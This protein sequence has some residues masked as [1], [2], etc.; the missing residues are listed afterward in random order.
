MRIQFAEPVKLKAAS[1][2]TEFDAYGRR[3]SVDLQRNERLVQ[4]L[5]PAARS[6]T[7]RAQLLRGK[8]QGAQ[9][10][11]VRLTQVGVGLEGAIWDGQEMYVVTTLARIQKNLTTPIAA[12]PGQTVMYRLS[13]TLDSLPEA[14]CGLDELADAAA[15]RG[16]SGLK[17]YRSLVNQLTAAAATTPAEQLSLSLI[18]DSSFQQQ[19]AGS[20]ADAMLARLNI[21]DGIFAEQIGVLLQPTELRLVPAGSDPFSATDASKLLDQ[22]SNFRANTPAVR[23]AGLAH[24]FTGKD[25][26]GNTIG[27]AY[28][29]ALCDPSFGASLS[30]SELGPFSS[31]LVMAHELGHNFGAEHDGTS[32]TCAATGSGYLMSPQF[33]GASV[34]SAC[35]LNSIAQSVAQ[36]RGIC[37]LPAQYADLA[38]SAP[39]TLDA[40]ANT[41]FELPITVRSIGNVAAIGATVKL[42]LPSILTFQGADLPSGACSTAGAEVTCDLG[43]IPANSERVVELNLVSSQLSSTS[44]TATVSAS[45]DYLTANGTTQTYLYFTSA[46]DLGVVMTVS[47]TTLF[48]NDT[49]DV[50]VDVTSTRTLTARGGQLFV[51]LF[52]MKFDSVTAGAHTCTIVFQDHVRCDLADIAAGQTTRIVLHGHGENRGERSVTA[53]VQVADD[54][55][56]RNNSAQETIRI[57]PENDFLIR[58]SAESLSFEP[59]VVQEVTYTLEAIGRIPSVKSQLRVWG[60][61][62]GQFD[63]FV[64]SAGTCTLEGVNSLILCEFG[65]LNPGASLTVTVRFHTT[66]NGSAHLQGEALHYKDAHTVWINGAMTQIYSNL[67]IDAIARTLYASAVEG[68]TSIGY[69]GVES[70]GLQPAQNVVATLEVPAP[71]QLTSMSV[72]NVNT[73]A[74]TLLTPQRGQC[75]GAFTGTGGVSISYGFS[76]DV[77]GDYTAKLTITADGDGDAANN[78][79]ESILTVAPFL[80][81]GIATTETS[82]HLVAGQDHVV[83]LTVTTAARPVPGVIVVAQRNSEFE[84]SSMTAAGSACE[85]DSFSGYGRCQLGDLPANAVVPVSV[86]Y[87]ALHDASTGTARVSVFTSTDHEQTNNSVAIDYTTTIYTD[88]QLQVAQATATAVSGTRLLFPRITISNLGAIGSRTSQLLIPLPAFTTVQSVSASNAACSGTISLSCDLFTLAPGTSGTI[89]IT[90]NTSST[91]NFTSNVTLQGANDSTTG[92]NSAVVELSVT[93]PQTGGG[94]G[95]SSGGGGG[96]TGGSGSSKGGGGQLEWLALVFLA[97][98][99]ADRARRRRL[100]R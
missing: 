6:Q 47:P 14:F 69:A 4:G 94:G 78:T 27:I 36:A 18:A 74:C 35:S 10:S 13:D 12:A 3:F 76:S 37:I 90:L 84:I 2:H 98:L 72:T 95:S 17:Q 82:M 1:G 34:F 51:S 80:D 19:N 23:T 57:S 49:F 25:L 56:Y 70:V 73:W 24:L 5:S 31:A 26:D 64:A 41:P 58:A 63:S 85:I 83:Q 60:P 28:R 97:L 99:V 44:I 87:R 45:N 21:V 22:L 7:A 88:L 65:D 53:Q 75:T 67:Q 9:G 81:A 8:L 68:R 50:T 71:M 29:D 89:D 52:D 92:N 46:V 43:D 38:A 11:W 33:N 61:W 79:S 62:N 15:S 40:Q 86:A 59:G 42:T 16:V 66:S 48:A 100:P 39:A 77:P 30:D 20:S 91:G 96:G 54:G 93:A 55:D 32:G